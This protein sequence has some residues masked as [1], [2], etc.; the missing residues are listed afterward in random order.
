MAPPARGYGQTPQLKVT[1]SSTQYWSHSFWQQKSSR[2]QTQLITAESMQPGLVLSRQQSWVP[3]APQ[4]PAQ[5]AQVSAPSQSP[6]P[7]TDGQAPQ[8]VLQVLQL[9]V[10]SQTASPQAGVH[11]PQSPGQEEQVSLPAQVPLPQTS[12]GQAP[13]PRL[14]TLATHSES[15]SV[16]QQ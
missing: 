7:H 13:Q 5:E 14:V 1:T 6:S 11:G 4:S 12:P 9:S 8:S 2:A 10:A 3:H 16:A 15:H